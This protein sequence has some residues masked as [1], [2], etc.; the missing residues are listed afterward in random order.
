MRRTLLDWLPAD[1]DGTR[2]LDAGCGTGA[3]ACD[4]ARRG[5][6]VH[7]VELAPTLLEVAAERVPADLAARAPIFR[8]GDMLDPAL[9]SFDY[10]LAMDSLIHYDADDLLDAIARLAERTRYAVLL[11]FAPRTVPLVL[12]HACGRRFPRA[13]RAP[14]IAPIA[15]RALRARL[16][17]E[18]RFVG[19]RVGRTR[20]VTTGFYTSQ[21]LELVRR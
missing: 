17:G 15:E 1:L 13:D 9:G 4:L 7:A 16:D 11:T 8:V 10:V 19:W 14:A 21:A 20:R 2:V 12:L 3:L 6:T 5:A 18:P